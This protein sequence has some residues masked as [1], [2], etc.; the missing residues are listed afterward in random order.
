[1]I[2]VCNQLQTKMEWNGEDFTPLGR[3]LTSFIFDYCFLIISD[4]FDVFKDMWL[5]FIISG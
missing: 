3:T 2:L 4:L 1:M 5:F